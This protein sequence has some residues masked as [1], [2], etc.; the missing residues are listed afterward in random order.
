MKIDDIKTR[1]LRVPLS[2]PFADAT[3]TLNFIDYILVAVHSGDYSG[4]CYMLSFD[5]APALL[6]GIVDSELKRH[7]LGEPADNIR[8]IFDRNLQITEYIG[9]SGLAMWGTAAIDTALWD[10]LGRRLNV[11]VSLLFGRK[12]TE[13]PAYG[14]GGWISYSDEAMSDELAGY[15][16]RGLRGVKIKI[17]G[18]SEVGTWHG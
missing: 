13:V 5:Y 1:W 16:K 8:A 9:R 10:L 2:P 14:S 11:P 15:L 17:G 7:L 6:K 4:S 3:H 18:P 12:T